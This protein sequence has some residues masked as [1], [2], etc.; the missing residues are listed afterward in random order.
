[1]ISSKSIPNF[2]G[3]AQLLNKQTNNVKENR[4]VKARE[5]P[6]RTL[7]ELIATTSKLDRTR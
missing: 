6:P 1:M 3:L 5:E 4:K 7:G 2:R